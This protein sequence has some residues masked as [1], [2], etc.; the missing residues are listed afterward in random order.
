MTPRNLLKPTEL[1]KALVHA[2]ERSDFD[3]ANNC[4]ESM[5]V[6]MMEEELQKLVDR[7]LTL[8]TVTLL[9]K[10]HG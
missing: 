6:F 4:Y 2:M 3:E 1:A 9:P 8:D 7:K 5:K 10:V